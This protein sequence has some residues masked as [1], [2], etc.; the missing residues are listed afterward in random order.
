MVLVWVRIGLQVLLVLC[1][2]AILWE[3]RAAWRYSIGPAL[4]MAPA[5]LYAQTE[6]LSTTSRAS[7][8]SEFRRNRYGSQGYVASAGFRDAEGM[9]RVVHSGG[10]FVTPSRGDEV[11]V[12]Y[13]P[14][15]L[16]GGE[17]NPRAPNTPVEAEGSL[18]SF[19]VLYG[20]ALAYAGLAV[21]L[22]ALLAGTSFFRV[23]LGAAA[24]EF[25]SPG[26]S[27]GRIPSI[28]ELGPEASGDALESSLEA[29]RAGAELGRALRENIDRARSTH[30]E[31]TEE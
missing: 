27:E 29:Q 13:F 6:I 9:L 24:D 28:E 4:E 19:D 30:P 16:P 2:I 7:D 10:L 17:P 14:A 5:P 11:E 18:L 15:I 31:K 12:A 22:A 23:S 20:R 1:A 21:V 26:S 25:V 3:L 8:P